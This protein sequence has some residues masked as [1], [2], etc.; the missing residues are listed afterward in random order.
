MVT[1]IIEWAEF[2]LASILLVRFIAMVTNNDDSSLWEKTEREAKKA[3][4]IIMSVHPRNVR[5]SD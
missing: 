2:T 1:R 5:S 4:N 3:L